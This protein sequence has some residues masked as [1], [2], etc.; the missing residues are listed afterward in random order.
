MPFSALVLTLAQDRTD[1]LTRLSA[2]PD[3]EVGELQGG[4]LP[5]VLDSPDAR[6]AARG[7][8]ALSRE[9]G[10]VHVDLIA[11]HYGENL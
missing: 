4:R 9:P 10:V 6:A 5:V 2:R 8:E 11:A 1:V 7:I 3:L